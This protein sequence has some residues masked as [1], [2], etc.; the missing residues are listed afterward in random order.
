MRS[1]LR[2]KMQNLMRRWLRCSFALFGIFSS[3]FCALAS[4]RG[5]ADWD[6]N[7]TGWGAN[8]TFGTCS[9]ALG[10]WLLWWLRSWLLLGWLPGWLSGTWLSWL[11]GW[12]FLELLI[13][14]LGWLQSWLCIW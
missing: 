8:G 2:G 14:L 6:F 10:S 5:V 7:G 4:P 3:I 1:L 12:L 9:A 13:R 11:R